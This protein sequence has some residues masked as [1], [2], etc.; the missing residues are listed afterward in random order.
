MLSQRCWCSDF[1]VRTET[2][3]QKPQR[4]KQ[5]GALMSQELAP[6]ASPLGEG[7][8]QVSSGQTPRRPGVD[9]E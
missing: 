5:A 3:Q 6:P 7:G 1:P 2:Q 8:T 4:R 9:C